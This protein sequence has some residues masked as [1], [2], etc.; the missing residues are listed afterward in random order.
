ME[1]K[2]KR[3]KLQAEYNSLC[4]RYGDAKLK[5]KYWQEQIELI[6]Q[7]LVSLNKADQQLRKEEEQ[8]SASS[9]DQTSAA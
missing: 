5:I 3:E 1:I 8:A 2:E 9:Q 6:E 7:E 4:A